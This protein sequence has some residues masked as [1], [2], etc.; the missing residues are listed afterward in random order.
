[1]LS[2]TRTFSWPCNSY[3]CP[4]LLGWIGEG[5]FCCTLHNDTSFTSDT[6]RLLSYN[7]AFG[8]IRDCH[9]SCITY[10]FCQYKT[11]KETDQRLGGWSVMSFKTLHTIHLR[12][13]VPNGVASHHFRNIGVGASHCRNIHHCSQNN[14]TC[15]PNTVITSIDNEP[16]SDNLIYQGQWDTVFLLIHKFLINR[17]RS[18]SIKGHKR[19]IT[20]LGMQGMPSFLR[21][22]NV[23]KFWKLV[24]HLHGLVTAKH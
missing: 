23:V 10:Y 13:H 15:V 16:T 24:T 4:L 7:S 6:D 5:G 21:F 11:K 1:M 2:V 3:Q 14:G 9:Y 19:N 17:N 18:S 8:K 22:C 20:T 12:Q